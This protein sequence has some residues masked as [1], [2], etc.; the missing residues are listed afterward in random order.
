MPGNVTNPRHYTVEP[1]RTLL[2]I[3][4]SS[5]ALSAQ[6]ASAAVTVLAEVAP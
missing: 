4:C 6:P 3:A 2:G 5:S 1:H